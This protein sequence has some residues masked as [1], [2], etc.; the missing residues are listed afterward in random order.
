MAIVM[1]VTGVLTW[2]YACKRWILE[3]IYV[4]HTH[5][6]MYGK[7]IIICFYQTGLKNP[8]KVPSDGVMACDCSV[9]V[10]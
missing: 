7:G 3:R 2:N 4:T 10:Y 5:Q 1:F 8:L 6:R 9:F